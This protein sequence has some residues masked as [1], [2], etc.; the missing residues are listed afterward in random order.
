MRNPKL[1]DTDC[2]CRAAITITI[3]ITTKITITN[4]SIIGDWHR[5]RLRH[6]VG[7][8]VR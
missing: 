3:T 7:G 4:I 1:D 6:S 8:E 5:F 2:G